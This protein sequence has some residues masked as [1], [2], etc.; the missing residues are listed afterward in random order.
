MA[1]P[2]SPDAHLSSNR[3]WLRWASHPSAANGHAHSLAL[4][5]GDLY[6]YSDAIA[7]PDFDANSD[8]DGHAHAHPLADA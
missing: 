5:D 6:G 7:H 3:R 8:P 4:A 1:S 2:R